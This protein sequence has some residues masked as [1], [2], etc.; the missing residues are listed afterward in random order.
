MRDYGD[1]VE[2]ILREKD[3]LRRLQDQIAE[4]ERELV[5]DLA[6]RNPDMLTINWTRLCRAAGVTP[7]RYR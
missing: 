7:L 4:E 5:K 3:D 1:R 6:K 2:H